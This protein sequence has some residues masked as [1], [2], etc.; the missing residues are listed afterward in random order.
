MKLPSL[1]QAL[2]PDE[3]KD[4]EKFLQSP[5]FKT[6]EQYL[7]YFRCLC[8]YY[9]GFH[10]GKADL[11]AAYKRCFGPDSLNDTKLYNLMS[12]LGKQIEQFLVV[13]MVIRPEAATTDP[14]FD[15]MLVQALG[16]R[17]MGAYFRK[18]AQNLIQDLSARPG[19]GAADYL[20]LKQLSHE[21]YFNPDTPK[22]PEHASNLHLAAECLDLFYFTSKLK[23][24]A[25][26]KGR[27]WIYGLQH[28]LPLLEAVL[29][30][31]ASPEIISAHPLL[32]IYHPL[33]QIYLNGVEESSFSGLLDIFIRHYHYLNKKE[34]ITLLPH[35]F[36]F[37]NA[38]LKQNISVEPALLSLY[39]FALE[40]N[41]LI[42]GNRITH[43]SF[44]SIF[45]LACLCGELDWAKTFIEQF[46][47][48]LS[49]DFKE[50]TLELANAYLFYN[51]GML[52]EAQDCLRPIV[53]QVDK[54]ELL[55]RKL[56]LRIAFDRY[57]L[58]G[59]DYEFLLSQITS[60]EKFVRSRSLSPEYKVPELNWVKLV[61]KMAALKLEFIKVPATNK[62][63]LRKHIKD[64]KPLSIKKWLEKRIDVL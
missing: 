59:K 60:F 47:P 12:G 41:T 13:R 24:A 25:E 29:A 19:K 63:Q 20:M 64:L 52:D 50:P 36:R 58:Q 51:Q 55:A 11:Q 14:L 42:I 44:M 18:E 57:I 32:E 62:E 1:L 9:P 8:K 26:I 5:I 27:E 30:Q 16:Q 23:Y 22:G 46:A 38:L 21:I 61:R 43:T 48:N 35:L 40:A 53:F 31:C 37:G 17:N 54:F 34:Q 2:H 45:N 10:L 7:K 33:I 49:N 4:F 56:L 3:Y 6:S 39:K 15:Q 28:E